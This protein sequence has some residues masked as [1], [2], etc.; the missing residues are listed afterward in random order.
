MDRGQVVSPTRLVRR[1]RLRSERP[2]VRHEVA[3]FRWGEDAVGE[4]KFIER[5]AEMTGG[6]RTGEVA[7]DPERIERQAGDRRAGGRPVAGALPVAAGRQ[8]EGT[9][10]EGNTLWLEGT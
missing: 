8:A 2:V 5:T 3:D 7:S 10:P 6:F 9:G 4:E 1:Q